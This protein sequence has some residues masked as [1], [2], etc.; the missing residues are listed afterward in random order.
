MGRWRG[1]TWTQ[2]VGYGLVGG[3]AALQLAGPHPSLPCPY[4]SGQ[5]GAAPFPPK[6]HLGGMSCW[7]SRVQAPAGAGGAGELDPWAVLFTA[8]GF[9]GPC[10]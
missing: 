2:R 10:G 5:P 1:F 9:W 4:I 8:G 7:S 6:S 3:G